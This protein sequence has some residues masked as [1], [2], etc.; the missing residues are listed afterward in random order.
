LTRPQQA[1]QLRAVL[2]AVLLAAT[3]RCLP[4]L[5]TLVAWGRRQQ[6]PAASPA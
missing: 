4:A 6:A 1:Q 3:R 5:L 2:L